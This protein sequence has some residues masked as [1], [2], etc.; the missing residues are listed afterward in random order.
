VHLGLPLLPRPSRPFDVVGFG[1]NSV[2]L[3]VVVAE[4]PRPDSKQRLQQFARLPGGQAATAMVACRRLGWRARYIGSFGDDEHGRLSRAS[5][6]E[7][8]VDVS[9]CRV[10]AGTP[11]QFA[12]ILVDA[13]H[14]YRTVLWDRDP[15]LAMRPEEVPLEAVT[16]GRV[17]L[18]DCHDTAAATVAARHA[19]AS[20][21]RTVIDVERVRPG[22]D[23]L[24][25]EIDVIIAAAEFPSSLTGEADLGRALHLMARRYPAAVVCATLGREGSLAVA[26]G[27]EIRTPG[28]SVPV[29]DTTGAGDVFRAGFIAA[30]LAAGDAA[31][32][33]ALLAYANA[34]A[35]LNC[36]ALGARSGIPTAAEVDELL[37][38]EPR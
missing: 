17:L 18:V 24:L 5:L 4:H 3:L 12:V 28:F 38:A 2:D 34:V 7:A 19:R 30:W 29:V 10:V 33:E 35:A 21:M 25:R 16:A 22:I 31:E 32:V 14:G 9:A 37:A 8:G 13:R 23:E 11:N 36:R 27:R 1:L 20:G 15:K 6:E 26:G